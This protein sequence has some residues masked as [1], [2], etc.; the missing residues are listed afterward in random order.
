[1][2]AFNVKIGCMEYDVVSMGSFARLFGLVGL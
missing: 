2:E 1:M